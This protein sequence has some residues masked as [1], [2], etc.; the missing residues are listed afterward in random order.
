MRFVFHFGAP[1]PAM[2]L[3]DQSMYD[4]TLLLVPKP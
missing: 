3:I 1:Q 4:A 2:Q